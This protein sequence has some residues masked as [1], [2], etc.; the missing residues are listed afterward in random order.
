LTHEGLLSKTFILAGSCENSETSYS[1]MFATIDIFTPCISGGYS[2]AQ[3]ISLLFLMSKLL[4]T[5]TVQAS[6]F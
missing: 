1:C 4:P 2:K 6:V 3:L 5:Y